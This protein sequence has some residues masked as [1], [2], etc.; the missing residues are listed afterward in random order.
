MSKTVLKI[1]KS[2]I[3]CFPGIDVNTE[4]MFGVTPFD[5]MLN[6]RYNYR[7]ETGELI[8]K[9]L[10]CWLKYPK[11]FTIKK[12]QKLKKDRLQCIMTLLYDQKV[13]D[14]ENTDDLDEKLGLVKH[15]RRYR[16]LSKFALD[17]ACV[18]K[19]TLLEVIWEIYQDKIKA[20]QKANKK[21]APARKRKSSAKKRSAPAKKKRKL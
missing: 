21:S 1:Q 19:K 12:F 8:V 5:A 3:N 9:K 7:V 15:R 18:S 17:Q 4:D 13:F 6:Y 20:Y 11:Q 10:D 16:P 14:G 2:I